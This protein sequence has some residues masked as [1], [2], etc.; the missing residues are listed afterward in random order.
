MLRN[1]GL[2]VSEMCCVVLVDTC[3]YSKSVV[4]YL[5]DTILAYLYRKCVD[6]CLYSKSVIGKV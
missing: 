6:S 3:L 4:L 1:F 2:F 5:V